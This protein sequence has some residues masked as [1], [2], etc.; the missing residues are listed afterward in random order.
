MV[1]VTRECSILRSGCRAP[2]VSDSCHAHIVLCI[3]INPEISQSCIFI[4]EIT[5]QLQQI[6]ASL[7]LSKKLD[8]T[9]LQVTGKLIIASH[10][11]VFRSIFH[12]FLCRFLECFVVLHFQR[13][14]LTTN[15]NNAEKIRNRSA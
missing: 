9:I 5:P 4:S 13:S 14:T 10:P 6:I 15:S 11:E 8:G 7:P 12:D 2:S 3:V 1:F